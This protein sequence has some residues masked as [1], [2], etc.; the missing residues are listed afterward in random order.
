MSV[1]DHIC[2]VML[3]RPERRNAYTESMRAE[4]CDAFEK[5]STN[6]DVRVV[7]LTGD[8]AGQAFCAGADLG[9]G[10]VGKEFTSGSAKYDVPNGRKVDNGTFRDGGGVAA[11]SVLRCTK[12]I[13][14]AMNG[15]AVGVGMTLPCVCDIRIAAHDAK[16]G[17]VFVRRGLACE[18]VSSWILPKLIG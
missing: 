3:S 11:L 12:P 13:I 8:P 2:T 6:E 4:L 1:V 18:S 7:V 5:A 14:A 9:T 17:F 10:D 16:V 15:T